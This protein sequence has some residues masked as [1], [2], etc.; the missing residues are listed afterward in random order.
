MYGAKHGAQFLAVSKWTAVCVKEMLNL[1]KVSY[2]I[3]LSSERKSDNNNLKLW[4]SKANRIQI[5]NSFNIS[6]IYHIGKSS[7]PFMTGDSFFVSF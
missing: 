2:N 7:S 3:K 4:F 1:S 6:D 5:R